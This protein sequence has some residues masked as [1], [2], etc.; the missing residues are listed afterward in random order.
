VAAALLEP[1]G[2]D[3]LV[4]WGFFNTAF[5][6]K[7]YMEPYVEEQVA[8]EMLAKD[9]GVAAEFK[10]RL[11][12][13]PGFAGSAKERLEFFYRRSPAWDERLGVYPVYRTVGVP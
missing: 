7:E 10:R 9:P 13:E 2:V 8:A 4:A 11:Q 12:E 6:A 1:T 5:E 3:S